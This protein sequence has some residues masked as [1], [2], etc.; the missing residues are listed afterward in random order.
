MTSNEYEKRAFENEIAKDKYQDV[1]LRK[2][3]A[4]EIKTNYNSEMAKVYTQ[5]KKDNKIKRFFKKL[6]SVL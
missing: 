1:M 3:L 6:F 2:K 4:S 5:I